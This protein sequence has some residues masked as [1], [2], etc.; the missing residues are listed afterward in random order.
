[1]AGNNQNEPAPW[2]QR[3][4]PQPA[5][6]P[7]PAQPQQPAYPAQYP[8]TGA[9]YPQQYQPYAGPG[10]GQNPMYGQQGYPPG[11]GQQAYTQ[12]F[13]G[14]Q[15]G[16]YKQHRAVVVLVLAI[17]GWFLCAICS[18]VAFFMA[19]NDLAEIKQGAMDPSG[20]QLTKV[21]YWVSMI[22]MIFF[23]FLIVFYIFIFVVFAATNGG[24][25]HP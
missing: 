23:A 10:Y 20:E 5:Y 3:K 13:G 15:V 24:R 16:Y 12:P 17:C 19:K 14:Q 6:T 25:S 1:M 9:P 2:E 18:P 7:P 21:G 11:Y 22:H 4:P 8:Q